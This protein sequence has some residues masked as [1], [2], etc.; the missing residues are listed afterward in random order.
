M[1]PL[2]ATGRDYQTILREDI[3][4]IVLADQLG[5][6]EAWIGEH[7]TSGTEQVTSPLIFISHL[8]P[9]TKNIVLATGVV[10]LPY[11]HPGMV[12][13]HVAMLDHL[14]RGRLIFGIGSGSLAS[15]IEF[16]DLPDGATRMAMALDSIEIIQRL[17]ANEPPYE[18]DGKFWKV[19]TGRWLWPDLGCGPVAR[20]YEG[21][22]PPIAMSGSNPNSGSMAIC[23]Q[24]G[25]L[26]VSASFVPA[27]TVKTHWDLYAA[28]CA[29]A[30]KPADPDLWRIVRSVHV[31]ETDAEAAAFVREAAS[32]Q[33]WYFDY[34]CRALE[35]TVGLAP[36][37]LAPSQPP[38]E[39]TP[40]ALRDACVIHG[41]PET[42]ARKILEF[43]RQVG[44]FG[45]LLM[46]SHDWTDREA[47]V[48]SMTLLAQEVM[49]RVNAAIGRDA[50][51]GTALAS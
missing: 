45:T 10:S 38:E 21:R 16:F 7:Y 33:D 48:R 8:L 43:R 18:I 46:C 11:Y 9:Q 26:P 30:G 20:P 50:A 6:A 51:A 49:P 2:H 25:W 14:A 23:A 37:R 22:I 42:V 32:P 28:E 41:S 5:Y 31:A 4:A 1:M 17:W 19:R 12:A 36:L 29:K 40:Q 13:A 44:D 24:R 34:M 35:R 27:W 15:D 39:L 3:E 47:M